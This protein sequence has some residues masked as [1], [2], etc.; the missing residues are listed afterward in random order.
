MTT[1]HFQKWGKLLLELGS[2]FN[3]GSW[4]RTSALPHTFLPHQGCHPPTT[5]STKDGQQSFTNLLGDSLTL[6]HP[7]V[8]RL[9]LAK[10]G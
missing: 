10:Q 3:L 8:S 5:G 4:W 7:L 6:P 2:G 9:G 1:N